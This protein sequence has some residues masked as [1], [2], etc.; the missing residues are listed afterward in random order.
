MPLPLCINTSVTFA[1]AHLTKS[2]F[3]LSLSHAQFHPISCFYVF[4][5]DCFIS[6]CKSHSLSTPRVFCSKRRKNVYTHL[7]LAIGPASHAFLKSNQPNP[8]LDT[9]CVRVTWSRKAEWKWYIAIHTSYN[10]CKDLEDLPV[11]VWPLQ[12][13]EWRPWLAREQ[14]YTIP[15]RHEAL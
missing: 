3:V 5:H 6:K 13:S 8:R 12:S 7:T 11:L 9:L 1:Q 14:W 4:L 10:L 15:C 2:I